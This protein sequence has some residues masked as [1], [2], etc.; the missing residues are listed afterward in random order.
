MNDIKEQIKGSIGKEVIITTDID[1]KKRKSFRC[2]IIE[3]Y[4]A[5]FIVEV[6]G[7]D[8]ANTKS[9]TYSDVHSNNILLEVVE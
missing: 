1:K 7:K 3:A 6:I 5:V 8:E 2:I 4:R 9:F